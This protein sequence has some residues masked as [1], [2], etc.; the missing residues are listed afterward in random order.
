MWRPVHEGT[1]GGIQALSEKKYPS[2][3]RRNIPRDQNRL[4]I[5]IDARLEYN[6]PILTEENR[7][8]FALIV[9]SKLHPYTPLGSWVK[10]MLYN[11]PLCFEKMNLTSLATIDRDNRA[12][13]E[14]GYFQKAKKSGA[15]QPA[16]QEHLA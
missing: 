7:L 5:E 9:E 16:L 3:D 4:Q 14:E 10:A 15:V 11:D 6:M 12:I 8:K 2:P 13:E 1:S